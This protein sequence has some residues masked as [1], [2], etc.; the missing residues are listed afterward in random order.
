VTTDSP[1]Q[2]VLDAGPLIA[3]L[4]RRDRHHSDAWRGFDQLTGAGSTFIAPLPIVFEVYKWLAYH[5]DLATAK[6]AL[7][8]ARD[9]LA[10]VYPAPSDLD[11]LEALADA[12]PRWTGSLE[13]ALVAITGLSMDIPVWTL[14]YRD[15]AA[16]RN[17]RFWTPA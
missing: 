2:V 4:N 1:P 11:R 5:V 8:M 14:N 13:D 7:A 15:L 9:A 17:L 16:F 3:L 10:I 12:M 6:R